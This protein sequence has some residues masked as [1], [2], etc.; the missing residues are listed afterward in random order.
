[1]EAQIT[2]Q[3]EHPNIVPVYEL[4]GGPERESVFYTMRFLRGQTLG[5]AIGEDRHRRKQGLSERLERV[6]L[7]RALVAACNAVAFANARGVVHRDL[8][9]SNIMLGPFGEVI[10]I[11]WGLAKVLGRA[12]DSDQPPIA[13][14]GCTPALATRAGQVVGTVA[15]MAPE[16]ADGRL[17]MIDARTD[18]YALGGILYAIL[19]GRHPHL[20]EDTN[21][22]LHNISEA[23]SPRPREADS[24]VPAALDAVCA[25]A[26]A[27]RRSHRY[28][29]ASALADDVERWLADEPVSVYRDPV[30]VRLLRWMRRHRAWAASGAA[31]LVLVAVVSTVAALSISRAR[32]NE[33]LALRR[34]QDSLTA[35][36]Q[37]KAEA[38]RRFR[39]ARRAIDKSLTGVSNVLEYYPGV[40]ALRARLLEQAALDYERLA[41]ETSTD[42]ELQAEAGRALLR[43]ANVRELLGDWQRADDAYGR[44]GQAFQPLVSEYPEQPEFELERLRAEAGRGLALSMLNRDDEAAKTYDAALAGFDALVERAPGN[45]D[46]RYARAVAVVNRAPLLIDAARFA[47]ARRLL[48]R[49]ETELFALARADPQPQYAHSLAV[50]QRTLG[51]VLE[52]TAGDA[53]GKLAEAVATFEELVAI[54]P[55]HPPYLEGLIDARIT[56]ANALRTSGHDFE[57]VAAYLSALNDYE[58]LVRARPDV[59]KYRE[60]RAVARINL[61]QMLHKLGW[62][63]AAR[64]QLEAALAEFTQLHTAS[65]LLVRYRE[66]LAACQTALGRV[67]YELNADADAEIALNAAI[68]TCT[69]STDADLETPQ[70]RRT[71]A[72]ARLESAQWLH[73][74]GHHDS[75]AEAFRQAIDDYKHVSKVHPTDGWCTDGLAWAYLHHGDFLFATGQPEESRTA[76]REALRLRERLTDDLDHRYHLAWLLAFCSDR[77]SSDPARAIEV[78]EK[79][80]GESPHNSRY[81]TLLGAAHYRAGHR[82]DSV[83][84]LER[85][86]EAWATS[87]AE[88]G[89]AD[90]DADAVTEF[91]LAMARHRNGEAESARTA[92]DTAVTSMRRNR[93]GSPFLARLRDEASALLGVPTR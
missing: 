21:E 23:P 45:G 20:G 90:A 16:Q 31:A 17:D 39:E 79:L 67:L 76:Y 74:Q 46:Y 49:A 5:D 60:A 42:P 24:S 11:D 51:R 18:V 72:A 32:E 2:G 37:A 92:W 6:R 54:A 15:Y 41:A 8:K 9:P 47:D 86:R 38:L 48:E 80:T 75:A 61:A 29:T 10:V 35:E 85:A 33:A 19:T 56:L 50:A 82:Q 12:D 52:H 30:I 34:A 81:W 14:T 63:P 87:V 73:K 83:K 40:Q 88:I 59:P 65:P 66:G 7:L 26:M 57:E 28:Q 77:S 93:P 89:A 55:D 25:K 3:L 27:K 70:L 53:A 78:C 58:T 13:V 71:L 69:E 91:F 62:N 68:G 1:M 4:A 22:V 64:P 44:G 36:R 43:L 84:A